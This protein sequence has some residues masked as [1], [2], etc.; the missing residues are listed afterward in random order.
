[1]AR[2]N[3][4]K[5]VARNIRDMRVW[6][7]LTQE[8]AAEI[9]GLHYKYYQKVESGKVNLTLDSLE[10]ISRAFNISIKLLFS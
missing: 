7:Q 1:M 4:R 6:K 2:G 10:K 9:S 5:R 3:L 8:K